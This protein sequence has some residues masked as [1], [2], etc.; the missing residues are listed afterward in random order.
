MEWQTAFVFGIRHNVT[1]ASRLGVLQG[2]YSVGQTASVNVPL[3]VKWK[4]VGDAL[5]S[6]LFK[7][8]VF[9]TNYITA[10]CLANNCYM[11]GMLRA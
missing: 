10:N 7:I 3:E 1:V 11:I 5:A 4:G 2:R 9:H 8:R 6:K